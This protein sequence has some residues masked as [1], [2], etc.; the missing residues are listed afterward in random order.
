M[1]ALLKLQSQVQSKSASTSKPQSINTDRA[2]VYDIKDAG[3]RRAVIEAIKAE[4]LA[5][6]K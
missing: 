4:A 5:E 3:E 2:H 1:S 6:R